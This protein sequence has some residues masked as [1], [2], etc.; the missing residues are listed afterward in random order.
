[1]DRLEGLMVFA[2]VVE[3]QGF[4][5]AAKRLGISKATVSREVAALEDRLGVRLLNRTTR[6]VQLTEVGQAFYERCARIAEEVEEA[7][8]DVVSWQSEPRG[9]LR[10]SGPVSFGHRYL[11]P[12]LSTFLAKNTGVSIDLVLNDRFVDLLEEGFDL[13]IRI[14]RLPDSSLVARRLAPSPRRVVA[15]PAYL[16]RAGHPAVP[17]DLQQHNCLMYTYQATGAETWRLV[18]PDGDVSVRVAGNLTANNGDAIRRACLDGLGA[19][20]LPTFMV[21]EDLEAGRLIEVLPQF[22]DETAAVYAVHPHRRH[23]PGKVRAFVDFLVMRCK[24]VF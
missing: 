10:I 19:A 17:A 16:E 21:D 22:V 11:A 5:A 14:A 7:E 20:L 4:S 15:S 23:V 2:R 8:R 3:E 1:M 13:A 12:M 24:E 9:V 6:R 18:G